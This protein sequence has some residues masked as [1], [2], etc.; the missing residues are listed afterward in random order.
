MVINILRSLMMTS[1]FSAGN[2]YVSAVFGISLSWKDADITCHL[3][4]Y[5]AVRNLYGLA[6]EGRAP[7]F[8]RYCTKRGV[9]IWCFCVVMLFPFLSLLQVSSASAIVITWFIDLVTAGGKLSLARNHAIY[10]RLICFKVL[11]TTSSWRLPIS[12]STPPARP[13]G[14]TARLWW[15]FVLRPK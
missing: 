5:C 3:K 6:L 15:V 2:T 4:T 13:K 10:D 12:D 9:P 7:K 14:W 1:I 8:L 11:S